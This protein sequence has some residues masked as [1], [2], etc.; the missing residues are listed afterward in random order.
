MV[1]PGKTKA[2]ESYCRIYSFAEAFS[3]AAFGIDLNS[4]GS[5]EVA[6][7]SLVWSFM[8]FTLHS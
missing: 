3:Y 1:F 5:F 2:K 8:R 6:L 4:S 7:Q